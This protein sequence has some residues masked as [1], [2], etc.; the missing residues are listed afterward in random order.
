MEL[1]DEIRWA[2]KALAVNLDSSLLHRFVS[3]MRSLGIQCE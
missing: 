1:I 3:R 2:R